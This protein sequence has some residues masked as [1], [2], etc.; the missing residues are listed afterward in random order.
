MASPAT[1][2][3]CDNIQVVA[4]PVQPEGVA[5]SPFDVLFDQAGNPPQNYNTKIPFSPRNYYRG[6]LLVEY[7]SVIDDQPPSGGHN[8]Y[9]A[10]RLTDDTPGRQ[11]KIPFGV[12]ERAQ[13][14]GM[15]EETEEGQYTCTLGNCPNHPD[16]E[17]VA[18]WHH[19]TEGQELV[20]QDNNGDDDGEDSD[21]IYKD[22]RARVKNGRGVPCD[23]C[24][25]N[26]RSCSRN[27]NPGG[28]PKCDVCR[29]RGVECT[30]DTVGSQG[31][32]RGLKA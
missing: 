11:V 31:R 28:P 12:P 8:W 23:E 3:C 1:I 5:V 6:V 22:L 9:S 21:E 25:K 10:L 7:T 14:D 20:E 4:P 2:L 30:W 29:T 24:S 17:F 32:R 13:A 27:M 18:T 15:I 19:F 26:R 16:L